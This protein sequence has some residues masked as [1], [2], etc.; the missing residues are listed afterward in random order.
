M[1]LNKLRYYVEVPTRHIH[2]P[3]YMYAEWILLL[4]YFIFFLYKYRLK[5]IFLEE[6]FENWIQD[7]TKYTLISEWNIKNI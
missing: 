3:M 2:V 7:V 5:I 6:I 4:E 1:K